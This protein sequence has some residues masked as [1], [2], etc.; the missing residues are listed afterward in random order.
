MNLLKQKFIDFIRS[1]NLIQSSDCLLMG[2]SGGVDSI[3]LLHLLHDYTLERNIPLSLIHIN[4][5]LRGYDSDQDERFVLK[6]ARYL[7]RRCYSISTTV[8]TQHVNSSLEE[9]ARH[10]RYR[11]F[12]MILKQICF[13]KIVLAHQANDQIETV[14]MHLFQGAGVRGLRG[15]L[16]RR[17]SVIRPLLFATKNEI[18]DYANEFELEYC[19]DSTNENRRFLRNNIRHQILPYIQKETDLNLLKGLQR[20]AAIMRDVDDFLSYEIEKASEDCVSSSS[21]GEILLDIQQFLKYF[22]IIQAGILIKIIE[23]LRGV[24]HPVRHFELRTINSIIKKSRSGIHYDLTHSLRVVVSGSKLIFF[25]QSKKPAPYLLKMNEINELKGYRFKISL[26]NSAP[27]QIDETEYQNKN[28]E[29]LDKDKLVL[30]L[31]VRIRNEGDWFYPLGMQNARKLQD[32]FV[33]EKL[34]NYKRNHWPIVVDKLDRIVWI[35]GYRID[36][37]FKITKKTKHVIK[38]ILL[39][40]T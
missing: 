7:G 28:I 3:V 5:Q 37:R 36:E 24:S 8:H 30:P 12:D 2:I 10:I 33:D 39:P 26:C 35:C 13:N 25:H 11:I 19:I 22:S 32:F 17:D 21:S 29:Y 6:R 18:T 40:D 14:L 34:E 27:E 31:T 9:A 38:L 20:S 23:K 16:P 4:H 1:E 15:I